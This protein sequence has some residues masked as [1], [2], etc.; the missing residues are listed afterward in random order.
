M[1][2]DR[3]SGMC[4]I[5]CESQGP[6]SCID[7]T[8]FKPGNGGNN[9]CVK[10]CYYS[11]VCFPYSNTWDNDRLA[12]QLFNRRISIAAEINRIGKTDA[13]GGTHYKISIE[14]NPTFPNSYFNLALTHAINREFGDAVRLLNQYRELASA[15]EQKLA[16]ELI[17]KMMSAM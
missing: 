4:R 17:Q 1:T 2:I 12:S 14:L 5:I 3:Y 8:C 15:D 13:G 10:Q 6:G 16:D 7:L 9:H 11:V